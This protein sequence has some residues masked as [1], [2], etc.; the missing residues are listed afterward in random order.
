MRLT[1]KTI[2]KLT[3][4]TDKCFVNRSSIEFFV[5]RV[6]RSLMRRGAFETERI[7]L[8]SFLGKFKREESQALHYRGDAVAALRHD[9]LAS[10]DA[11]HTF[12]EQNEKTR[13]WR[14]PYGSSTRLTRYRRGSNERTRL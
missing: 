11:E 2:F 10:H 6:K 1:D 7:C 14:T 3:I 8:Y 4:A 12:E 9:V 5:G 13:N